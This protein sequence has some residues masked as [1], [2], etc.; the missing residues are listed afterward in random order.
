MQQSI[1][2]VN[3]LELNWPEI[4][5]YCGTDLKGAEG[6]VEFSLKV[7]K[8]IKGL[9]MEGLGSRKLPM[10]LC[11]PCARRLNVFKTMETIG[12]IVMFAAILLPVLLKTQAMQRITYVTGSASWLG[13]IAVGIWLGL[14]LVG[15]GEMGVLKSIGA[16]CRFLAPNRW[17]LKFHNGAFT[18]EFLNLNARSIE[19]T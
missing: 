19:R 10:R 11:R 2:K 6:I 8:G 12:S 17:R 9:L 13:F 5:P 3:K 15:I 1:V 4:C 18:N 14:I 7:K 16:E